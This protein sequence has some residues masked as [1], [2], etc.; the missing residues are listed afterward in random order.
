[1]SE[2]N[3]LAIQDGEPTTDLSLDDRGRVTAFKEEGMP[4]L[5]ALEEPQ[6]HRI[7]DLYLS[8]K[9]YRQI[10]QAV[11]VNKT[12]IMYLSD[13]FGW[14]MMRREYLHEL[15]MHQRQKVLE[16]KIESKD[17]LLQLTH[18]FQKKI[19]SNISKYLQTDD[20]RFAND[21]DLKEVDRY[22]KIVDML[23]RLSS[24]GRDGK[25]IVGLNMGDG[26]VITKKSNNEVEIT[27]KQKTL[28]DALKQFADM[29]R[30]EEVKSRQKPVDMIEENKGDKD[31]EDQ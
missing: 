2:D 24:E 16:S 25:P 14:Y 9:S 23:H 7:M 31:N 26:V 13:R 17:F 8:G 22:I 15:E 12:L 1:M 20:E 6:M 5:A 30:E 19:G 21:I 28:R 27:P 11:R 4:G 10:S 3:K 29:R 18:M